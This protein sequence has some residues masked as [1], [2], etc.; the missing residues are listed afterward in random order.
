M[1]LS[2][3]VGIGIGASSP[4]QEDAAQVSPTA[5]ASP[6]VTTATQEP[7]PEATT[8]PANLDGTWRIT[9]CDLQLF[10]SGTDTSTLVGAVEV[11]NTGNVPAQ[12]TVSLKWDAIPGPPIDGGT[13]SVTLKPGASRDVRFSKN[14]GQDDVSRVQ[15]S[16]GYQSAG[17][18]KLCKVKTSIDNA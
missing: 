3:L 9:S 11:N 4:D 6:T 14:I 5:Q 15:S 2:L 13:K 7:T 10:T 18:E 8:G 17:A 1:I 12:I 16:P